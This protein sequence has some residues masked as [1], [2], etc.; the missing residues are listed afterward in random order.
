[1][2]A[3]E[4][5]AVTLNDSGFVWRSFL[6]RL[7]AD[8]IADDL[9]RPEIWAKVQKGANAL[10]KFDRL[11]IVAFDES[12]LAETIVADA[13]RSKAILA[14][15]RLTTLPERF[16]S[17][18]QDENY[19]VVWTGAGYAVQRRSDGRQVTQPVHSVELA[20]RDLKNMYGKAA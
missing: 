7:P 2:R 15:P 1:M 18:L 12:W 3:I 4:P 13:D 16:N 17:P 11:L 5:T 8:A 14:K 20:E 19:K 9:K 10:R 6:V